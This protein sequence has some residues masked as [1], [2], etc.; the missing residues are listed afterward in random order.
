MNHSSFLQWFFTKSEEK[1]LVV[2][3]IFFAAFMGV[4]QT[5]INVVP[6]AIFLMTYESALLTDAYISLGILTFLIGSFFSY[7][8]KRVS[9]FQF[10]IAP[11]F[12]FSVSLF[13]CWILLINTHYEFFP[14]VLFVWS[15]VVYTFLSLVYSSL[16]LHIFTLQEG[17]KF[18]GI[19]SGMRAFGGIAAGILTPILVHQFN[20]KN[21]FLLAPLSMLIGMKILFSIKQKHPDRF[22]EIKRMEESKKEHMTF[23][24]LKYKN[25]I[26]CLFVLAI[27]SVFN[28]YSLDLLFNTEVKRYFENESKITSFLGGFMAL[29]NMM[30]LIGGFFLF[31]P[32]LNKFGLITTLFITPVTIGI[33]ASFLF[34]LD[35]TSSSI[36][37]LFVILSVTVLLERMLRQS[38]HTDSINLLYSP[39]KPAE[40]EWAL[41]QYRIKIQSIFT[42]ITGGILL[43]FN[44]LFGI[45][46]LT[47]SFLILA[48]SGCGICVLSILRKKYKKILVTSLEKWAFIRPK[49]DELD[50]DNLNIIKQHLRSPFPEEVI[51]LLRIIEN[52]RSDEFPSILLQSLDH[53][54]IDVRCYVL[55][56]IEEIK[57]LSAEEKIKKMCLNET[58]PK[59]LGYALQAFGAI[60]Y[61]DRFSWFKEYLQSPDKEVASHCCNAL[62]L[63]GSEIQKNEVLDFLKQK[64]HSSK[65]EDRLFVSIFL[66]IA[67]FP[68]KVD[69]LI[70][71]LFDPSFE[72]RRSAC[73]AAKKVKDERV[74]SGLIENMTIPH[75]YHASF[76]SLVRLSPD[77]F[78]LKNFHSYS[79]SLQYSIINLLGFIKNDQVLVFLQSFLSTLDRQ[80][81]QATLHALNKQNF[82]AISCDQISELLTRENEY[83]LFLEKIL[84]ELDESKVKL[85]YDLLCR[86]I[87]LIQESCFLLLSFIYASELIIT[88]REGLK[89]EDRHK[90][91]CA[92]EILLETLSDKDAEQLVPQLSLKPNHKR[93]Q[94]THESIDKILI[95]VLNF[96]SSSYI[97]ALRS[98]TIYTIGELGLKNLMDIVKKVE[99][100]NDPFMAEIRPWVIKKLSN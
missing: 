3:S 29:S 98:A 39:L 72:V 73:N 20:A 81:F 80:K 84:K 61:L 76:K 22:S 28:F 6:L 32:L 12:I 11:F 15:S 24:K 16:L 85:L 36:T 31:R 93:F 68:N 75:L 56:K 25:Y 18:F 7:L 63:Y 13:I 79:L 40:K 4:T 58:N 100:E 86:E 43:L 34:I 92:I 78:L 53:P 69:F 27:V 2:L 62:L 95:K 38:I 42:S 41:F 26:I 59:V 35:F 90:N 54:S 8:Q 44:H 77:E 33:C 87:E 10:L 97:L 89:E 74:Y 52:G 46:I 67:D 99:N 96:A 55:S 66:N 48:I 23:R 83:I 88:A 30:T 9:F 19:I 65:E 94:G 70:P 51:Y 82:K 91:S 37:A 45:H 47:I 57:L 60:A 50:K 1:N 71:L 49:F 14:M 5:F 64:M 17:K 21:I